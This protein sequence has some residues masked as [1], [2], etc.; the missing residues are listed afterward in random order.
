MVREKTINDRYSRDLLVTTSRKI[1]TLDAS[2]TTLLH[3]SVVFGP[4]WGQMFLMAW[5]SIFG[6]SLAS[7]QHI[8]K[9][10]RRE[11][12]LRLME[13]AGHRGC[14]SIVNL[15]IETSVV[16]LSKNSTKSKSA[17]VEFLAYATGITA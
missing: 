6:G 13:Q 4:S 1:T 2:Q 11:A 10:G 12:I 9:M 15:R 14:T 16:I 3:T 8:L 5:K 17:S 7:Y